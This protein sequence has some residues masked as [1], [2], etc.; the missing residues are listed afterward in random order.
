MARLQSVVISLHFNRRD[1][2]NNLHEYSTGRYIDE[3]LCYHLRRKYLPVIKKPAT[4]L[5]IPGV[6]K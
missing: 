5:F 3:K 1:T 4:T 2:E 6:L